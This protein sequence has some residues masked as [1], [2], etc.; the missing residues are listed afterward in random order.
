MGKIGKEREK[1]QSA[2]GQLRFPFHGL[3]RQTLWDTVVLS[4]FG[5][6]Q[7][8]PETERTA[9]CGERY[10]HQE[11][12]QAVRAGQVPSSLVLGGRHVEIRR[13]RARS[14]DGHELHL[15]S[16]QAWSSQSSRR[17]SSFDAV[18]RTTQESDSRGSNADVRDCTRHAIFRSCCA[19]RRV[20]QRHAR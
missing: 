16:W 20:K 7:A 13:P 19:H 18:W 4:G 3:A 11:D 12:R 6:V 9:L 8:E 14:S 1:E 5:F 10:A 17:P 2:G 15:P